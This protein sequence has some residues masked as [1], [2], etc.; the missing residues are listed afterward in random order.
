MKTS[1]SDGSV[2]TINAWIVGISP[3]SCL[4]RQWEL[5]H[6]KDG[7]SGGKEYTEIDFM[8]IEVIFLS[9][10]KLPRSKHLLTLD[11]PTLK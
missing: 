7:M 8:I 3:H 10:E 11:E 5:P 4:Q 1:K 2:S 6:R 9:S